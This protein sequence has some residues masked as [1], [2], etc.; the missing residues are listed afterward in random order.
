MQYLASI[1]VRFGA[2]MLLVLSGLAS[3]QAAAQGM[4]HGAHCAER[5]TIAGPAIVTGHADAHAHGH[6]A[7]DEASHD[8][9]HGPC[10]V[11]QC[12]GPLLVDAGIGGA[13]RLARVPAGRS[14][15]LIPAVFR[16]EALQRPPQA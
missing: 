11:H 8:G 2:V 3:T 15:D 10:T 7:D 6:G 1:L 5:V 13:Y 12:A 9:T 4:G 16:P 14:S